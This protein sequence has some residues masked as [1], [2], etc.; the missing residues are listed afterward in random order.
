MVVVLAALAWRHRREDADLWLWTLS[1]FVAVLAGLRFFPHYYLQ[2]LPPLCILATRT[3][4]TWPLFTRRWVLHAP[5]TRLVLAGTTWYYLA[6]AFPSHEQSRYHDRSR[7]RSL[8]ARSHSSGE[9]DTRMGAIA[10]G[11]LG[12]RPPTGDTIRDDGLPRPV[13]A[14]EDP[15]IGSACSTRRLVPRAEIPGRHSRSAPTPP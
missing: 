11:L 1:G 14:G 6:Q 13:R 4:T 5:E 3:L 8:R 7:C 15:P 9:P 10:R 12:V 2:L